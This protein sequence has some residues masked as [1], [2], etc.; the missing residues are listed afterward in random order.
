MLYSVNANL[1]VSREIA[2]DTA[3]TV[4]YLFT[5]GDHIPIVRNINL[6]PS[7]LQLADGRPIFG[8]ARVYPGFG[9]ILTA[10]SVGQS[11]YNA[12][13]VTLRRRLSRG[14]E[15]FASYTWSHALDDAPEQNV[16]DSAN[17]FLS[18]PTNCRRDRSNSLTDRPNV[19]NG[20]LVY[21]PE[22]KGRSQTLRRLLN[23]NRI[24]ILAVM[25]SGD[26]FNMRSNLI[27]NG[28]P[29]T[30][31]AFQR[32]LFIGRNTIRGPW[33]SE[34]NVRYSRLFPLGERFRLEFIAESTNVF[35]HT[36]VVGL[37]STATVNLA[38][39]II[40]PPSLAWTTALDQRLLQ[41]G[42][43]LVFEAYNKDKEHSIALY[44]ASD[45][46]LLLPL[47]HSKC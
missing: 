29:S 36:N 24:A 27:L 16:I 22:W 43:N 34:F 30:P 1:S 18:D 9:N 10:E 31:S 6:V 41:L 35:N 42:S 20:N 12:L 44:L 7:G 15:V 13:N 5:R 39:N 23:G 11:E 25:Q 45:V 21:T 14:L 17:F 26:V 33:I 40:G 32:P 47:C 19:F 38:G 4:T 28:D 8:T 2:H 3:L 46:M 37:N